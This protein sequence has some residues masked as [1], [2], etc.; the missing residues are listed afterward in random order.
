MPIALGTTM[1]TIHNNDRYDD[2]DNDNGGPAPGCGMVQWW[3][4]VQPLALVDPHTSRAVLFRWSDA[5]GVV[6]HG[7]TPK[8]LAVSFSGFPIVSRCFRT[9][10]K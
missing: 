6:R 10:K 9:I 5:A 8:S 7:R 3:T 4:Q 1:I 2:H